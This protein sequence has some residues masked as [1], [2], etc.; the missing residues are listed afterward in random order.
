MNK[1]SVRSFPNDPSLVLSRVHHCTL[2]LMTSL[3]AE[4][5]LARGL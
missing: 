4:V 5:H 3:T 2:D 1:Q